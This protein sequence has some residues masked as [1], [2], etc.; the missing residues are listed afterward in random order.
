MR[1]GREDCS[2]SWVI[3]LDGYEEYC[4]AMVCKYCGAFACVCGA[5]YAG[6]YIDKNRCNGLNG[7]ANINGEWENPYVMGREEY[8]SRY[9]TPEIMLYGWF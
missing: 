6:G 7:N 8:Y 9:Q 2:H 3:R 4:L 5:K 1:Y